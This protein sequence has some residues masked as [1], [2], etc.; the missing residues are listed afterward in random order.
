MGGHLRCTHFR[1]E[2]PCSLIGMI[3][4]FGV[5]INN[6]YSVKQCRNLLILKIY[7]ILFYN[8]IQHIFMFFYDLH[9][10][11]LHRVWVVAHAIGHIL[12]W[13]FVT[14]KSRSEMSTFSYCWWEFR[15]NWVEINLNAK[16]DLFEA[17]R[18]WLRFH[19]SCWSKSGFYRIK[20]IS[21]SL[22]LAGVVVYCRSW[23]LNYPVFKCNLCSVII[24]LDY[25]FMVEVFELICKRSAK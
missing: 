22:F 12:R 20:W 3:I 7:L 24:L 11:P 18:D 10:F 17:L 21:M 25:I 13:C 14:S 8:L 5:Y 16:S 19:N 1:W 9:E 4:S 15:G 6:I 2:I 23:V